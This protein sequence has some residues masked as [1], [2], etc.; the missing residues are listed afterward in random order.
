MNMFFLALP[1]SSDISFHILAGSKQEHD[2]VADLVKKNTIYSHR[3][4]QLGRFE[5]CRLRCPRF[6]LNLVNT[7]PHR[8]GERKNKVLSFPT[9]LSVVLFFLLFFFQM[10]TALKFR[11][12][13]FPF[14]LFKL[15]IV[16]LF[17]FSYYLATSA[18][19]SVVKLWDLRKL[20]NFKTITLEDRFE[21]CVDVH[22]TYAGN[23]CFFELVLK[24]QRKGTKIN[25]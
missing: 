6:E 14:W 7:F 8:G 12:P 9:L 19:D 15:F 20:K 2:L 5:P 22:Q 10:E 24:R 17:P 4:K 21:V 25:I 16:L 18:D 1:C 3:Q 23:S 13:C 11:Y